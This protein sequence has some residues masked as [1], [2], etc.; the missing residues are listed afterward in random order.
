MPNLENGTDSQANFKRQTADREETAALIRTEWEALSPR[1]P[2]P[3]EC[4][5]APTPSGY[6]SET[7]Q[8]HLSSS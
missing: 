3:E 1:L 8:R 6:N 7:M 5:L 2:F 4:V